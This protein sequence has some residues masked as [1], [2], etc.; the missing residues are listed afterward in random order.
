M[1]SWF[2]IHIKHNLLDILSM[3]YRLDNIHYCKNYIKLNFHKFCIPLCIVHI[4]YQ[5]FCKIL[6][7]TCRMFRY[8]N[9]LSILL[10]ILNNIYSC[11]NIL[12]S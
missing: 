2:G 5:K 4:Y 9:I 12:Q 10:C 7:C 1:Y 8:L 11:H 6:V 3:T